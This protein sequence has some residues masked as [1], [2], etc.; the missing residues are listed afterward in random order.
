ML[1]QIIGQALGSTGNREDIQETA[2]DA[3]IKL[4]VI[5]S[6][7][8]LKKELREKLFALA[9]EFETLGVTRAELADMLKEEET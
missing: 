5:T 1:Q 3:G 4:L 6:G 9:T 7:F 8:V 2:I